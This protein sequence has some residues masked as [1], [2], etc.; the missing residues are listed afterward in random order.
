MLPYLPDL[1]R[2]VVSKVN[3]EFAKNEEN[4]IVVDFNHGLESQVWNDISRAERLRT[5]PLIWLVMNYQEEIG[6]PGNHYEVPNVQMQIMTPTEANWSQEQRDEHTF[7]KVLFPI[8]EELMIQIGKAKPLGMP[9]AL[10]RA[11]RR[12]LKPYWGGSVAGGAG[13]ANQFNVHVDAILIYN[14]R[15]KVSKY[16]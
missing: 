10:Q 13:S 9:N 8:Y 2:D 5:N 3:A 6:K 16:C 12:M 7:R 1:L 15:L 11:H 4:E 14:L